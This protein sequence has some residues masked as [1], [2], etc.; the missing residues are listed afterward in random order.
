MAVKQG[1]LRG[2]QRGTKVV[3][4]SLLKLVSVIREVGSSPRPRYILRLPLNKPIGKVYYTVQSTIEP[5][6]FNKRKDAEV[7]K[8]LLSTSTS[9]LKSDIIRREITEEGYEPTYGDRK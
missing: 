9:Q 6:T 8:L 4:A 7:F 5:L 3:S 2:L 1:L